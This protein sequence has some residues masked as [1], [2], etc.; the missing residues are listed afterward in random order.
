MIQVF[1]VSVGSIPTCGLL[2]ITNFQWQLKLPGR[3]IKMDKK[4]KLR[5][6]YTMLHEEG[7]CT[8]YGEMIKADI[9]RILKDEAPVT[10]EED[11]DG[12]LFY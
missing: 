5:S 10:N 3:G 6:L 4:E 7:E 2:K 8:E 1:L 12:L 9:R 11:Q